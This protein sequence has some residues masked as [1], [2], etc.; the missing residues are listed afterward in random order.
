[1]GPVLI[2]AETDDQAPRHIVLWMVLL[3]SFTTPLMLSAVNVALPSIAQDLSLD[4]VA[5]SWVPLAYLMASAMFVLICGRLADMYGRKRIFLLGTAAVIVTSIIAALSINSAMLLSAR[6]LQGISAAM[7]YATQMAIVSS[8]YPPD[9]RG[10]AIGMAV[11]AVYVGLAAGPLV[12]GFVTETLGWRFNFLLQLPLAVIVLYLGHRKVKQ[13]WSAG[14]SSI[15]DFKGAGY[16]SFGIL[17]FCFGVSRLPEPSAF[18]LIAAGI[19]SLIWFVQHSRNSLN[20]IWDVNLFFGN[21][22]FT[23]SCIASLLMYSATYANVVLLSL[24]LQYLKQLPAS[25][26]GMIMMIQPVIMALL[27]PVMGKLS[28]SL[29]PRVLASAGMSLTAAGLITLALLNSNSSLVVV[30]IALLMTGAGFSLFSPPNT[31]AIMGSVDKKN[32]GS[33]SGAVAT[34]RNMGQLISMVVV[35]LAMTL[36]MGETQINPDNYPQLETA[37]RLSF[38]IAAVICLPGIFFSLARGRLHK[39]AQANGH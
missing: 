11:S 19:A 24:Y 3:N 32:F 20:P 36:V 1:M 21:R 5:I 35:T 2:L 8:V 22:V 9:Q 7:L 23:L 15:I 31:N 12:G 14:I 6:F 10:R 37:I 27:A 30:I 26:A 4:A 13:E 34:M 38:T 39:P 17:V 18:V 16:Y 28:D 25:S 33:A 29:E